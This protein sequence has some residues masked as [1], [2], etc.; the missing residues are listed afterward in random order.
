VALP[1]RARRDLMRTLRRDGSA[2]VSAIVTY[3]PAG[4]EAS[5]RSKDLRLI[6][7]PP[8]DTGA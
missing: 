1:I 6:R 4:G 8:R 5:S 2:P 7:K 3:L